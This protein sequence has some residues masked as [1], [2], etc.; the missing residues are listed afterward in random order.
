MKNILI[1]TICLL[2]LI[3]G[4]L[5]AVLLIRRNVVNNS[6]ETQEPVQKVQVTSAPAGKAPIVIPTRD[7][8]K[9]IEGDEMPE[10]NALRQLQTERLGK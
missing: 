6:A 5:L 9:R 2:G 10:N 1:I 7:I 8:N 3:L 4:I